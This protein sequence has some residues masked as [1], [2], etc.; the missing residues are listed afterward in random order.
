MQFSGPILFAGAHCDDVELFAGGLLARA[1]RASAKSGE[2]VGLLVLSD[3]RGVLSD[4][5]AARAR[6]ELAA[7]VDE[8]RAFGARIAVHGALA[9][10]VWLPAC[11][12]D[13][14]ARRGRIYELF[15]SLRDR[16]GTVVTHAIGDTNQDHARVAEEARRALKGHATV[17]GGEHPN[18]DVGEFRASVYVA[19]EEDDVRAKQRWVARY[20]SQQRDGRPYLDPDVIA[21]LARVRGSQIRAPWAEAYEVLARIVVRG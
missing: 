13:F 19:L 16:Y 1:C 11:R 21:A 17:L 9:D 12:G 10:D 14:D 7:N 20:R 8:L 15:E 2:E 5:D 6:A 4:A 18:N 3:H